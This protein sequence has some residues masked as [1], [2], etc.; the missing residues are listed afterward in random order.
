MILGICKLCRS[1]VFSHL[2]CILCSICKWF[3]HLKCSSL[4]NVIDIPNDWICSYCSNELFPFNHC[5]DVDFKQI[6]K[7]NCNRSGHFTLPALEAQE[8]DLFQLNE[9]SWCNPVCDIDPDKQYF[10]SFSHSYSSKYFLEN[11]FNTQIKDG[12][13]STNCLSMFHLNIRSVA[14]NLENLLSYLNNL[15]HE[16]SILGLSETWFT[17]N[18]VMNYN[19]DNYNHVYNYRSCKKGG[20]VSLFIRKTINFVLHKDL[21]IMDD[22]IEPVFIEINKYWTKGKKNIIIGTIYRPP[23]TDMALFISQLNNLFSLIKPENNLVY[24]IK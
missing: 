18:N 20:G 16:F 3:F 22:S 2:H 15:D 9:D 17:D 8:F 6:I 11:T 7:E 14:K 4:D 24:L 1:K 21:L 19:I 23:N 12:N 5:D 13:F 10:N